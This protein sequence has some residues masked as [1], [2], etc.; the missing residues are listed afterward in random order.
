LAFHSG[1]PMLA[2]IP[3]FGSVAVVVEA[4][5]PLSASPEGS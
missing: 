5:L 1:V 4:F 2:A 3:T